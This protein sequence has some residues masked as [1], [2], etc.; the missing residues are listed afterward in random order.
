MEYQNPII[1]KAFDVL[2]D[3]SAD[4]KIREL[5]ER[6][7]K[8]LKDEA[9]YLEEVRR[10]G[11]KR[12]EIQGQIQ[13]YQELLSSGLLPKDMAEQKIAQLNLELEKFTKESVMY[14]EQ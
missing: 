3:L 8:T 2:K 7:E 12:G 11:E 10:K 6:R 1:C 14:P 4:G 13:T 9:V 5:A